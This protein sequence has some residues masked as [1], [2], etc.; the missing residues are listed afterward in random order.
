M[1]DG[2]QVGWVIVLAVPIN[3]VDFEV[4]GGTFGLVPVDV[5]SAFAALVWAVSDGVVED[6]AVFVA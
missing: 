1:A 3:V 5:R 2:A 6:D 4:V